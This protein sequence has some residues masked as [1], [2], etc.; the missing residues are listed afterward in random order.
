MLDILHDDCVLDSSI[1]YST[2]HWILSR[3]PVESGQGV[4][5]RLSDA[6]WVLQERSGDEFDRYGSDI[7]RE[8][9]RDRASGRPGHPDVTDKG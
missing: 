4:P 9:L 7:L 2:R 1:R 5:E 8:Q 3:G 6:V